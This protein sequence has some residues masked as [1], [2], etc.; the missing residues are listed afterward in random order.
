M[1]HFSNASMLDRAILAVAPMR[2][3]NRIQAKAKANILMN[4]DA[5]GNG[6]RI[7]GWKAPATDAD[8]ASASGRAMMRQRSRDLIRNA[9]F[10]KRAQAIIRPPDRVAA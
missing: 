6:R 7:K 5:G 4:Y 3:L 9:P 2:G 1:M 10:A 8:A